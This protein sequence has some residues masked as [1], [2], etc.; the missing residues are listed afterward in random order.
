MIGNARRALAESAMW[1]VV[2]AGSV[3]HDSE[4]LATSLVRYQGASDGSAEVRTAQSGSWL[5]AGAIWDQ[6]IS[7]CRE[8]DVTRPQWSAAA[9]RARSP[10]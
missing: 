3:R 1:S 2:G 4:E 9:N 7:W 5:A 8:H 6:V 10:S